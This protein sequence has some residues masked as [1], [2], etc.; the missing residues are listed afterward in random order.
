[1]K[2]PRPIVSWRSIPSFQWY[3]AGDLGGSVEKPENLK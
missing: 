3:W 1:M 2:T